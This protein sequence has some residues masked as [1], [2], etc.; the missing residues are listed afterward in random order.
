MNYIIRGGKRTC[1]ATTGERENG[2]TISGGGG[3]LGARIKS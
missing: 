1:D 3:T 2:P